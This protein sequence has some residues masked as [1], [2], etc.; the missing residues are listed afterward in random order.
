M[1]G[2]RFKLLL[3]Y[4]AIPKNTAK[5][6]LTSSVSCSFSKNPSCLLIDYL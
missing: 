6:R 3:A 1:R 5:Q 2:I 4:R